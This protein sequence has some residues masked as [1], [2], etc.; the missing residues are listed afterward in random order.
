M[1][2]RDRSSH[3]VVLLEQALQVAV[4]RV[5]HL[6][7]RSKEGVA[8]VGHWDEVLGSG[9]EQ[10]AQVFVFVFVSRLAGYFDALSRM[11]FSRQAHLERA[12]LGPVVEGLQ[13]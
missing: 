1:S 2:W 10:V 11:L 12:H 4:L 5:D 9:V 7:A 6:E 13:T 8:L 3:L